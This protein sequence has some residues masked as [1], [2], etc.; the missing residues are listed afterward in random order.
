MDTTAPVAPGVSGVTNGAKYNNAVT[1]TLTGLESGA[2]GFYSL[3]GGVSWLNYTGP[4]TVGT[5]GTYTL[6][7]RQRD[8]AGNDSPISDPVSF[9][10]NTAFPAIEELSC[11]N[12]DGTYGIGSVMRFKLVFANKVRTIGSG[13]TV[14]IGSGGS[15]KTAAVVQNPT[16]ASVLYFEYTVS[17]GDTFNPVTV[18]AIDLT[19]VRDLYG[20]SPGTVTVP[21]FNRPSLKIDGVPPAV[22]NRSPEPNTASSSSQISVT[23]NEPIFVE[24]GLIEVSR[25]GNWYIPVVLTEAEFA[26]IYYSSALTAAD[27]Q[28]LMFTDENGSPLLHPQTGQPVGPYRKITHGLKLSGS[29]YVPDTA[30]K[31]VLDFPF[32]AADNEDVTY[33]LDLNNDGD[34]LD[35]GETRTIAAGAIRT[36]LEKTGY[37]KQTIDVA[38]SAVSV[39]NDNTVTITLP[40]PLVR[41]RQW[42]VTIPAGAFRDGAGNTN[43]EI[44]WSFWSAQVATPVIRVDRYSHGWGAQE[45]IVSGGSI[46]GYR[47]VGNADITTVPT[48]YVRVRIDCETPG[49]TIQYGTLTMSSATVDPTGVGSNGYRVSTN[50]DATATDL[51]G[52]DSATT[53]AGF[54]PLGDGALDTAIKYYIAAVATKEAN[55]SD[56]ALT[57]SDRGYEG[58]FKSIIMYRQ[59]GSTGPLRFQGSNIQGG[60]PTIS[61]FPLRDAD[62]DIRFSKYA[63]NT[64]TNW[65]WISWEIVSTWYNQSVRSNWQQGY[66]ENSYGNYLYSYKKTY[67]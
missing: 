23:F 45:P 63:Y 49:A 11:E 18:S 7:A 2:Q 50:A 26:A 19:N 55:G 33:T 22:S 56:P 58:A 64:G 62:P 51:S 29:T 17:A 21:T 10:V 34:T 35:P 16:G 6:V 25:T 59:P 47:P 37:H 60:M 41:G 20:N 66:Y 31:Y 54:F 14:T 61:G 67:W 5:S 12:P 65:Y 40:K 36:V 8:A 3:N 46:T 28:T 39:S 52:I 4:V 13:A 30:T 9:E 38:S 1:I 32:S 48:G 15:A 53:Y 43:G 27:R 42:T 24:S 44:S 57:V